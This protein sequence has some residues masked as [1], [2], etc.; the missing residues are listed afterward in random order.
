MKKKLCLFL[1][2]LLSCT[3]Y[4]Q[5]TGFAGTVIDKESGKAIPGATVKIIGQDIS[6][7]TGPNGDFRITEVSS[8]QALI[9]ISALGYG[10]FSQDANAVKGQIVDLG[11]IPISIAYSP[12][13]TDDDGLITFDES[14][15]DDESGSGQTIG[16][17]SGAYDD[18]YLT[19]AS[20]A[21]SAA[22]FRIRG[23]EPEYTKVYINGINFN[24]PTRGSFNFSMLG[25]MNTAFRN[26]DIIG[27]SNI[28]NFGFGDIGGATN[29]VTR[30]S[31]YSPGFRG[32]VAYTNRNY[33]WRAMLNYST[34]LLPNGW[35]VTMSLI[36]RLGDNGPVKGTFYNSFGYFVGIEK[37]INQEHSLS[38]TTFG[39]PT[40]RGQSA[41]ALDEVYDLAG[42]HLYN[43]NWGYQNGKKRNA[44]VVESFD[45]TAILS[46]VYKPQTGTSLTTGL[47]YKYSR[48][49]SSA[50]N[51]YN[52]PDPRPDYYRRLPSYY[53]TDQTMADYYYDMWRND[54]EFRQIDWDNLYN[55]NRLNNFENEAQ[56][57]NLGSS[58][59]VEN[60]F[61]N[62]SNLMFNSTI[63]HRL[64][65]IMTL[66]GGIGIKY[67]DAHYYK[68]V[69]DLLGGQFWLDVDQYAQRDFPD[70]PDIA[71]NN[72]NNPNFEA[73]KG[74][75]FGYNYNIHNTIGNIWL[76]NNINLPK[77][78]V[79]YGLRMGYSRFY[80]IGHMRN[81]R[82]PLT[83]FGKGDTHAFT[84]A[85]FKAGATYKIDGRNFIIG[86]IV[87]ET[88]APYIN[89]AYISPKIKD[90]VV[91]DL[92]NE[93]I[94]SSDLSYKF[95]YPKL[96]G[97]I[98]A[99]YTN[100]EDQTDISSFY[101]DVASTYV[102]YIL[103]GVR[104]T[105]A[106]VEIGLA[107]KITPSITATGVATFSKYK[108]RNN[109][110]GTIN[111]ENGSLPD[112]TQTVYY[113]NVKVGGTPQEAFNIGIDYAAPKL[114][115]FDVNLSWFNNSYVDAN[116][117]RRSAQ[118]YNQILTGTT[119]EAIAEDQAYL[120][121][122]THQQKLKAAFILNMSIGKLIYLNRKA[123][124]NIN[125]SLNNIL[126]K[127]DLQTGGYEQ[128]RF[129]VTN[130]NKFPNKYYYGQGFN[131]FANV[132]FKF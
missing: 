118:V 126:N 33:Q 61:S 100:F 121:T 80:R 28:A 13:I 93:R 67:T 103:T 62:Q 8:G 113:K 104:K 112:T 73:K 91:P 17:L 21:F 131:V 35:A 98:T 76:Q 105:Y 16:N 9:S 37:K 40:Q 15:L 46:W 119:T 2:L 1:A 34:G 41:A 132:G 27:G 44:K 88:H 128:G 75:K 14:M 69:K 50:L 122:V 97:R 11:S 123:S 90:D 3:L 94:F 78:D 82:N 86:N 47:A 65:D 68:N 125:I 52:A 63:N 124:L 12:Y 114:W 72:L 109:P 32:S 71:Q 111:Y 57:K 84:D 89:N 87:Y 5:R 79:Y 59:I 30:A 77:W 49:G 81:G 43:P 56:G 108:Y 95:A 83:S 20:Y 18:I 120:K 129:D 6:V 60:R 117:V 116:P 110:K 101:T 85:G 31:E 10:D 19:T 55:I 99:F 66:Q 96:K 53:T 115:F 58:Y 4:A 24:D 70:N 36:T 102:N 74:D 25:G 48:Y 130:V 7:F 64:N 22:R 54:P 29:I 42:S 106:G 39:A 38:L 45:P 127:K 92:Q 51:W 107:Y 23:Y 26:K